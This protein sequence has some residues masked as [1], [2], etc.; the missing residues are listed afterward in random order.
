MLPKLNNLQRKYQMLFNSN[1][2]YIILTSLRQHKYSPKEHLLKLCTL[3]AVYIFAVN[4][5]I[6]GHAV[7]KNNVQTNYLPVNHISVRLLTPSVG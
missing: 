4:T 6:T 1:A 3:Y 7:H 2:W 5:K